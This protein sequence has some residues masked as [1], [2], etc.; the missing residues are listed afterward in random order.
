MKTLADFNK[1][2]VVRV[3]KPSTDIVYRIYDIFLDK[4]GFEFEG[5]DKALSYLNNRWDGIVC[6]TSH[7]IYSCRSGTYGKD[8]NIILDSVEELEALF[9]HSTQEDNDP[10]INL[11]CNFGVRKGSITRDD[12]NAMLDMLVLYYGVT[13]D[14]IYEGQHGDLNFVSE[15]TGNYA[16]AGVRDG[17]THMSNDDRRYDCIYDY[18]AVM[19]QLKAEVF[20][21]LLP[22]DKPRL[23]AV[24][25]DPLSKSLS[26]AKDL[27]CTVTFNLKSGVVV[28]D[29]RLKATYTIPN[30]AAL[31]KLLDAIGILQD[32]YDISVSAQD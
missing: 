22:K 14:E 2:I 10:K 11:N 24:D 30:A 8:G 9:N 19:T 17:C 27:G 16:F 28:N 4:G 26:T 20:A 29:T 12:I 31:G 18:D 5:R 15:L 32:I 3:D 7:D 6:D 1:N 13:P 25:V 21:K 23:D